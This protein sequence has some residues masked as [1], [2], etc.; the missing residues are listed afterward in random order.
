GYR[1][2]AENLRFG[3][4]GLRSP[5]SQALAGQEGGRGAHSGRAEP[6]GSLCV[7]RHSSTRQGR[8]LRWLLRLVRLRMPL[9]AVL[10]ALAIAAT[11]GTVRAVVVVL[12]VI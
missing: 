1:L 9:A 12:T 2:R 5:V 3:F 4:S 6:T 8:D 7:L 10:R 11:A